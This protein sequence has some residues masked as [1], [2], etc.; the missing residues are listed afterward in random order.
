MVNISRS[1]ERLA[2][3]YPHAKYSFDTSA[4]IDA[5]H[6]HY[7]PDL[8]EGMWEYIEILLQDEVI[9][10]SELVKVELDKQHDDLQRF[11]NRHAR[12]VDPTREEQQIVIKI[13]N[14]HKFDKWGTS[15][16]DRGV[17]G[18]LHK[19]AQ[20]INVPGNDDDSGYGLVAALE[21]VLEVPY[22]PY[23]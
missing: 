12:F 23:S 7:P 13:V 20:D 15:Q 22:E 14:H 19:T 18:V 2:P 10:V 6:R 1:Q 11:V 21:A 8:F 9:V 5:W 3:L 4:F 17:R 16:R